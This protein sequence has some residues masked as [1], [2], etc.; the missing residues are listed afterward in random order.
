MYSSWEEILFGIP[1]GSILDFV[2]NIFLCDLYWIMFKTDFASYAD[3][4]T[5]YVSGDRIDDVIKPVEYDS[6]YL[7]KWF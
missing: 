1:K 3:D 5:A 4:Y 2:F 7:F 6:T